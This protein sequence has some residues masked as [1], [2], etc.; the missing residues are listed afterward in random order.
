V[1][2]AHHA[3]V[4]M[5]HFQ[6]VHAAW[7][8]TFETAC[9]KLW[10]RMRTLVSL[11]LRDMKL[12]RRSWTCAHIHSHSHAHAQ[13]CTRPNI[14]SPKYTNVWNC[15][16]RAH[17]PKYAHAL[18]RKRLELC[19]TVDIRTH[20]RNGNIYFLKACQPPARNDPAYRLFQ[21]AVQHACRRGTRSY[22]W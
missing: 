22:G 10:K 17:W 4:T 5:F 12:R 14:H 15:A 2:V 1:F 13:A 8:C 3:R 19:A 6:L 18:T 11:N 21:G 9:L 20:L 7:A 16:Q